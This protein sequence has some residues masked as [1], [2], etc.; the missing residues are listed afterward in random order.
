MKRL[1]AR[2]VIGAVAIAAWSWPTIDSQGKVTMRSLILREQGDAVDLVFRR[3]GPDN[4]PQH[5]PLDEQPVRDGR[6]TLGSMYGQSYGTNLTYSAEYPDGRRCLGRAMTVTFQTDGPQTATSRPGRIVLGTTPEGECL[7][8]E[9]WALESDGT[10]NWVGQPT[11][12]PF[13]GTPCAMVK[14]RFF[15]GHEERDGYLPVVC[16]P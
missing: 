16:A 12:A 1:G 10:Q 8:R 2:L 11:F 4:A 9:R 7:P 5:A 6:V 13:Q 3:A 14:V 15:D